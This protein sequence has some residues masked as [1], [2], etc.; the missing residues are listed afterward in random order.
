MY[1][2]TTNPIFDTEMATTLFFFGSGK[3]LSVHVHIP[4]ARSSARIT[5]FALAGAN[6]FSQGSRR[7]THRQLLG[8]GR[9]MGLGDLCHRTASTGESTNDSLNSR[10]KKNECPWFERGVLGMANTSLNKTA[11]VTESRG[12]QRRTSHLVARTRQPST[13]E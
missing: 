1:L 10:K 7:C 2:Y 4:L 8:H 12:V 13:R 11:T 6:R 3:F 5:T 9:D